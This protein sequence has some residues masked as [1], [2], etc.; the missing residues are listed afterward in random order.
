MTATATRIVIPRRAARA[1]PPGTCQHPDACECSL[2]AAAVAPPAPL[3]PGKK[4]APAAP[5]APP[6]ETS[7]P[8]DEPAAPP[9]MS[10]SPYWRGII[11]IEGTPTGDGRMIEPNALRWAS[12]PAPFRYAPSDEGAHAGAQV[13][14]QITYLERQGPQIY[15]EGTFD[16][17]SQIGCEAQRQVAL[18]LTTGVSMDLDEIA[19]EYRVS[20]ELAAEQQAM[21]D[22]LFA[23][24]PSG[25][26]DPEEENPG[27]PGG[28][29][30]DALQ[31]ETDADGRVTVMSVNP[32]DEMEVTTGARIRAATMVALPAFA[33]CRIE[34]MDSPP[35]RGTDSGADP[36]EEPASAPAQAPAS[37]A[38]AHALA[39]SAPPVAPPA[40]WFTDP[41]F[42]EPTPV[43]VSADGRVRGHLAEWGTCHTGYADQCVSPPSSPSGY[44][45]FRT[46]AIVTREGTEIAVGQLTMDTRHA[47]ADAGATS[48][49]RH[50][51]HTGTAVADVSAGEDAF[52][53][54]VAGA[55]RPHVT[56]A[57]V[58]TLR[59]SPLSG[60]WRRIG[61][62]LEMIAALAVN[63]QGFPVPRTHG[64][65]ASGK[66]QALVAS[67]MLAPR[68]VI[69][70]GA[71]GAF[72]DDD[73]R[74]LKRI[75]AREKAEAAD[76][77]RALAL[78]VHGPA[79]RA[80]LARA[81]SLARSLTADA[82]SSPGKQD[83]T[84]P[85]SDP[86]LDANGK[87]LPDTPKGQLPDPSYGGW[88][89]RG[90][91]WVFD[92]ENDG[93]DDYAAATDTDHDYWDASGKQLKA[94]PASPSGIQPAKDLPRDNGGQKVPPP[95]AA[96][97]AS[98]AIRISLRPFAAKADEGAWDADAAMDRCHSAADF[99]SIAF[100]R[101]SGEPGDKDHWALPH[102]NGPGEPPNAKGVSSAL[103][104]FNQTDGL[105]DPAAA[106]AH[107]EAHDKSIHA[108][109][110]GGK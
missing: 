82:V 9:A 48:A 22:D 72:S 2:R 52:G 94:I 78:V 74:Y 53:I 57:Q 56:P 27:P 11:G 18:G 79:R 86:A 43:E 104:R 80:V 68:K 60:D 19:F 36:D 55:L 81:A 101:T 70:P 39:A 37:P 38:P 30:A 49:M 28:G 67:G 3:P 102:H 65:V 33:D 62:H 40:A 13:A 35:R 71:P 61:G 99:G 6:Q 50:Y 7:P 100:P 8:E 29:E 46:G 4:Q 12:L 108:G 17:G 42:A 47:G 58:R 34:L 66:L 97:P 1:C 16:M 26:E 31:P 10:T 64:L 23:L 87:Q 93:D 76:R 98:A 44:A 32:D 69:P 51:D 59:A 15:G 106:K 105:A 92:P 54:W 24:V 83:P 63:V 45:Y 109:K 91:Q 77:A 103:G 107:L 89:V 21:M 41:H 96:P 14:G 110:P 85:K 73:L 20:A 95:Q 75:L 25:A 84:D 88:L 90:G 5:P